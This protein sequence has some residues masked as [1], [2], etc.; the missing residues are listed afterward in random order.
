ML[1]F[2]LG[3]C[4]ERLH[5]QK[6]IGYIS[7]LDMSFDIC[8]K[9][10]RGAKSFNARHCVTL[11]NCAL[12]ARR[13]FEPRSTDSES[14]VLTATPT[15]HPKVVLCAVVNRAPAQTLVR[16]TCSTADPSPPRFRT[17]A[18]KQSEMRVP[19]LALA[20]FLSTAGHGNVAGAQNMDPDQVSRVRIRASGG[21]LIAVGSR[22]VDVQKQC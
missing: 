9:K 22:K 17:P 11:C 14:V 18:R 21:L 13:G 2:C 7:K 8:P 10:I 4:Y 16:V 15:S 6:K 12:Q 1:T 20:L 3:G 19:L 5:E